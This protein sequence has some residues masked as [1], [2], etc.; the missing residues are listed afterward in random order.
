MESLKK[1]FPYALYEFFPY[2][3]DSENNW[4]KNIKINNGKKY[5]ALEKLLPSQIWMLCLLTYTLK[6]A[7]LSG[8]EMY[9][10]LTKNKEN[11]K[12]KFFDNYLKLLNIQNQDNIIILIK[13]DNR[14]RNFHSYNIKNYFDD[15]EE[16]SFGSVE[17]FFK[18]IWNIKIEQG[19]KQNIER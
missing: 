5:L 2:A 4:Y 12:E 16:I 7:I 8:R 1:E 10:F 17:E 19:R 18:E 15:G 3:T 6:K 11:F 9:L 14:N 13:K